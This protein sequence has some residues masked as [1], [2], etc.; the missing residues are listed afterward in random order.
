MLSSIQALQLAKAPSS[1]NSSSAENANQGG[2]AQ[3]LTLPQAETMLAR[4]VEEG[5]FEKSPKGFY[6]LSPRGLMEL[7]GWLVDT[8]NDD[9]EE[10]NRGKRIKF[11]AACRDII[12]IVSP[13]LVYLWRKGKGM[14]TVQGQRC[15]NRDCT[16]RLHDTC[17]RN[18]FRMQQSER[19]PVCKAE[20]PGDKYV[21]ERAITTTEQYMQGRRRSGNTAAA[22]QS[23]AGVNG[24]VNGDA[25]DDEEEDE[26]DDS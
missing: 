19:C 22:R 11:C 14:L 15:S 20:W 7:R 12:T 5:W 10:G 2:A 8:Y 23:N 26:E 24:Q 6:S 25:E 4:L 1:S 21:G 3:S 17:I 13:P 18:F 16:G 9:D